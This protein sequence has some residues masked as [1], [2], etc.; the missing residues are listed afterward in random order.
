MDIGTGK[1]LAE[2]GTGEKR[3]RGHLID[4]VEPTEDYH[5]FRY[6]ED[7]RRCIQDVAARGRLPIIAGGTGLY[8]HALLR[9]FTLEGGPPDPALRRRITRMDDGDLIELLRRIAPDL[10]ERAD[11]SQR[12]RLIRAAEIALT[13]AEHPGLSYPPLDALVL[14]VWFPRRELHKRI[15]E[16]LEARIEEGLIEEV[17]R[18]HAQGVSWERLERFGLEYRWTALLL[19][20]RIDRETW[21]HGL[22]TAIRRFCRRQDVWFRKMERE[23]VVIHWIPRGDAETA[24]RLVDAWRA[25]R[26]V[27]PP[28]FRLDDIVYDARG[29]PRKRRR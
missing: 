22:L 25:G 23:G 2:Y 11:T 5:L 15:R 13:R 6:V 12:R 8:L 4:V 17:Q 14:G 9:G 1:D 24:A 29:N 3:V 21:F 20:G 16:R 7:A 10:L 18:L 26:H 27:P 28:P 19:Q